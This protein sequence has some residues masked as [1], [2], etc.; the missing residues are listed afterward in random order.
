MATTSST[1]TNFRAGGLISG[2]DTNTLID[3]LTALESQ[4]LNSLRTRQSAYKSQ[5]SQ[6]G[7]VV[8]KL[9]AFGDA[10]KSLATNGAVGVTATSGAATGFSAAPGSDA[11]A[12]RY[13]IQVNELATA[14]RAR[15]QAFSSTDTVTGG[16]LKLTVAGTAYD[17]AIADGSSL[18]AVADAIKQSGAP[19][20]AVVL[21]DGSNNYL[22][23]TNKDTGYTIGQPASSGLQISQTLTGSAGKGLQLDQNITDAKNASFTVNGLPFTRTKNVVLDAVPHTTLTLKAKTTS[24]EA[25]TLEND[26]AATQ[27]NLT[28]F[29]R[30][31]NDVLSLVQKNLSPT[32]STDRSVTLAGDSATR[33]LQGDLQ[34]LISSVV[35]S[36]GTVRS[37]ADLGIKTERDGSLSVE[38]A[39][40]Q[41]ALDRD[42]SAVNAVFTTASTGVGALT[43]NLVKRYTDSVDGIYTTR[44]QGLNTTVKT[45]DRQADSMQLR[46]DSYKQNLIA[47]FTAMEKVIS[48]LKATGSFLSSNG[49]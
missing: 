6:I 47:Q 49:G 23:V 34:A 7:N 35:P 5:I 12:G 22:S 48:G 19:V 32:S 3:Q 13:D 33:Q 46:I 39:K 24:E 14:A 28:A 16:N 30:G 25:L 41:K 40:L 17:V 42:P 29:V 45:M 18:S 44:T 27:S 31:Y 2:I 9:R 21:N 38:D 10:V 1:D 11:V 36:L 43:T 26:K 8:S 37:L 20:N 4:P 15:S